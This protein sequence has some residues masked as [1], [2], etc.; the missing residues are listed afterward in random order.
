MG[1][2]RGPNHV[3]IAATPASEPRML[4]AVVAG[5][6]SLDLLPRVL[7][8]ASEPAVPWPPSHYLSVLWQCQLQASLVLA[9]AGSVTLVGTWRATDALLAAAWVR[10]DGA[11]RIVVVVCKFMYFHG[12]E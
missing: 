7:R 10:V 1:G 9:V 12:H 6:L 8:A 2:T 3:K 11:G 5:A 4:L